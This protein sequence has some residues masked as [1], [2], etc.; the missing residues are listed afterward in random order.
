MNFCHRVGILS[1]FAAS[2]LIF[3]SCGDDSSSSAN[4]LPDEVANK[5]ELKTYEC[6]IS[7]IGE[8]IF[9]NDLDKY[10]E[11]DGDEW[12]ESYD[13]AK[14][15]AKDKSS[16]SSKKNS[17]SSSSCSQSDSG[18]SSSSKGK[19]SSS[20][21]IPT[22]LPPGKYDCSKYKCVSTDY[23]NPNIEYGELLDERD[24]QVYRTVKIGEQNWM[25]QNL[26]FK[27]ENSL[28]YKDDTTYCAKY[29]RLY[30]WPTAM[31][32][33]GLFSENGEGCD[34]KKQC[35]PIFP[36]QGICPDG[37]HLPN[38]AEVLRLLNFV[39]GDDSVTF[40]SKLK[41]A[42]GWK[43]QY[44]NGSDDY[45]FSVLP[46]G[47]FLAFFS[48][49]GEEAT[50]WY[51][52]DDASL[53]EFE[54]LLTR[55]NRVFLGETTAEQARYSIRCIENLSGCNKDRVG[56]TIRKD[57]S[58][59]YCTAKGWVDIKSSL[60]PYVPKE[61]YLNSEIKYDSIVDKR[62]NQVYKT[63]KI[64]EQVWMAQNLNYSDSINTPSLKGK[65]WCYNN[66]D[67]YCN[68]A[69]RLYTWAAAIDS[70]ALATD[71]DKPLDCGF[72]K[73]C[74]LSTK[75]RGIC[76]DGWHLPDTT[77]WKI[78]KKEAVSL[79]KSG[80]VLKSQR[81]WLPKFGMY[82]HENSDFVGFSAISSGYYSN[83]IFD[84]K[85]FDAYFLSS[86]EY[87]NDKMYHM[88]LVHNSDYV[89]LNANWDKSGGYSVRCVKD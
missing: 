76:P 51:S 86:T 53:M 79:N 89:A 49:E 25:A 31:D 13:Q 12:F 35:S 36:V 29:G 70:V 34:G 40:A 18:K 59:F 11:C 55:K 54:N 28:C 6:N 22:V 7:I 8:K 41:S 16:S 84:R 24:N 20:S 68:V 67:E 74:N 5:A 42:A 57:S 10:Y 58:L 43:Y 33:E 44:E 64:G 2:I 63:V 26:N 27:V 38:G 3:S 73:E 82:H 50:F 39:K 83:E 19:S 17:S 15:N 77:D 32:N 48:D 88:R 87:D 62:D 65:T 23:L 69:G 46:A 9:V 47:E 4:A 61:V 85:G 80:S 21:W 72:G 14:S 75:I 37:W 45:G 30:D 71:T 52:S 66:K 56:E 81:S 78:L 60:S 1:F